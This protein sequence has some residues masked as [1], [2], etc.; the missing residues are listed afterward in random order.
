[1]TTRVM[2]VKAVGGPEALR[3]AEAPDLVPGPGE[4]L[5]ETAATG[6]NFIETY[7]RSG[8]YPV[9]LPFV[10]GGEEI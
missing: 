6:V 7:Q 8:L 1:M 2:Q 9:E 3:A 5:V 10:P 4:L